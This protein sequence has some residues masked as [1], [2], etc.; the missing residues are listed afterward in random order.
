MQRRGC[1]R[2]TR[3]FRRGRREVFITVGRGRVGGSGPETATSVPASGVRFARRSTVNGVPTVGVPDRRRPRLLTGAL[4]VVLGEAL[5]LLA[6]GVAFVAGVAVGR[7]QFAGQTLATAVFAV[8]LAALL[9]A[10]ARGLAR[11]RRWARA[12]VL[13]W[14]LLQ[15][16]VGATQFGAAPAIGALLVAAALAVI[17]GLLA[18]ASVAATTAGGGG[19]NGLA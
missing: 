13:T 9:V 14:Q 18:P 16:A 19:P 3:E 8:G 2:V 15:G 17:V 11:G 10:A 6:A 12:P 4:V 1:T 5:A 7:A